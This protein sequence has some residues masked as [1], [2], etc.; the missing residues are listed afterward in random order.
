MVTVYS[1]RIIT[2]VDKNL[3]L[4]RHMSIS[5]L[6]TNC[7]SGFTVMKIN[8]NPEHNPELCCKCM[9]DVLTFPTK[10]VR[11]IYNHPFG[12][13]TPHW[14]IRGCQD[15]RFSQHDCRGQKSSQ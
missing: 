3:Y 2:P 8:H 6:D 15:I 9:Q 12:F 10:V 13:L 5:I 11:R 14:W 4:Y 1:L 7:L